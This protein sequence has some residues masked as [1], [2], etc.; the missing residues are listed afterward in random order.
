MKSRRGLTFVVAAFVALVGAAQSAAGPSTVTTSYTVGSVAV[1]GASTGLVLDGDSVT[2]TAAGTFCPGTGSCFGPGGDA[3]VDT[4]HSG[5]GGFVAPGAPAWGLV[6]RVGAGAWVQVGDGPTTLSG[7][8]ELV[9]AVNDDLFW[10]NAGSFTVTVSYSCWPG[11][12]YGDE[13]HHHCGPPGLVGKEAPSTQ[14]TTDGKGAGAADTA[15]NGSGPGNGNGPGNGMGPGNG[16]GS[17]S[18]AG[19]TPNGKG[20]GL[21]K[22]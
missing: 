5:Y 9:F 15:P 4:T 14:S 8:G 16:N 11:W 7:T 1:P 3:S 10:D 18:A 19:S 2:V 17:S 20:N 13:N 6:A 12:G 21:A 22:H